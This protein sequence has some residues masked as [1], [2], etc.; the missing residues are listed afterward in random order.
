MRRRGVMGATRFACIL[1]IACALAPATPGFAQSQDTATHAEVTTGAGSTREEIIVTVR[2]NGVERGELVLLRV[3]GGDFWMSAQDFSRLKLKTV[4]AAMRQAGGET[5]FSLN[6]LGARSLVF[7]E[8]KLTLDVEFPVRTLEGTHIDLSNRPPPMEIGKPQ[9]SAILNY[10]LSARQAGDDPIK[11][12]LATELNVRVGEL[13]L[14]QEAKYD[15]G[16]RTRQLT[17]G[18]SQAIWDDRQAGTRFIA[19][20]V[21]APGGSFGTTFPA[22]GLSLSR[23]YALTPDIIRQPTAA[24]VASALAPASVEVA[25]D[26]N[27]VYRT[28]VAPG[29]IALDNL[30]YTGGARTVRVTVTDATGRRQVVEQ[31]F[32]FTDSALARGLH[33]YSYFIGRRSELGADDRWRYREGAWQALHRYGATD[34][35]TVQAG[36]EGS[37]EFASGGIGATLRNNVL[38]LLS[39]DLLASSD[40]AASR[41]AQGW[42]ARYTY[43]TANG[44]L[45]A[46][47]RHYAAGFRT[48]ATTP[49]NATLLSE[50]R[51]AASTRL[52]SA[53]TLSADLVRGRDSQGE[54]ASYAVRVSSNLDKRTSLNAEYQSIRTGA[55]RDWALNLYLRFDLDHREWASATAR[56]APASRG[57]DIEAGRQL[58]QGEGV[59]YRVGVASASQ[60]GQDSVFSF[61]SAN[62]NL[63]PVTLEFNGT[64]QLRGGRSHYAEAAVSGSIVGLDGYLGATRLVGDGF[65]LARLGVPQPGVDIF[66]NNQVQGKTD[67]QGNLLIPQVGAYGRQDV[68]LDDK[69]LP[70]QY[71]LATKRVTIAPPYRSGTIVDFGGRKLRAVT[72]SAWLVRGPVRK[73]ITSRAWAMTAEGTSLAI[74]TAPAGDFYLE[75]AGPGRYEGTVEIEGAV[76]SCLMTVPAFADAV[77]ELQEGVICE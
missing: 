55:E 68:S 27:T 72:G 51:L 10:R 58:A 42:S 11:L 28:E 59:G 26:G 44:S 15:S 75:D 19:G 5:Y 70:M 77:Y 52:F 12:R 46:G 38:G 20:D 56:A 9:N 60:A 30:L 43:L 14:R 53:V 62:W 66:L 16:L 1:L 21:L 48:F 54:R 40:R 45:F 8:A 34:Y 36:G 69:Q 37:R 49:G 74:E 35:L 32:L 71:N 22:A 65:A 76:Y 29:P 18:I 7:D 39:L 3:A 61:A 50:T 47:R 73:P 6:A 33:E 63:K 13:L 57:F 17:R 41:Q 2:T 23:L 67:A 64:S 25:V 24:L 31:A 4:E